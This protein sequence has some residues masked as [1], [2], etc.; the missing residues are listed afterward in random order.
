M[1]QSINVGSDQDQRK[2]Y[3]AEGEQSRLGPVLF[4]PG[5]TKCETKKIV[6]VGIFSQ[7]VNLEYYRS[8]KSVRGCWVQQLHPRNG[9]IE[10]Q[11]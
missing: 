3:A 10:D 2:I 7:D 1:A 4:Y 9:M 11:G 6:H 5:Y 8:H